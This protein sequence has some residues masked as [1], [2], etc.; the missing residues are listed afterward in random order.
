METTEAWLNGETQ[1]IETGARPYWATWAQFRQE[2]T[3]AFE[4]M[5]EKETVQRQ[6]IELRQIGRVMG[7]ITKFRTLR[8]KIPN[9]TDEEAFTLF[10]RGLDA[11]LQ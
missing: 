2:M 4:P 6:I 3:A 7:Y 11:W 5:T 1:H 10:V 8:Y 9:M